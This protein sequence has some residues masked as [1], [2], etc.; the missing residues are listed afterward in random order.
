MIEPREQRA[1]KRTEIR[2]R[3]ACLDDSSSY[4]DRVGRFMSRQDIRSLVSDLLRDVSEEEDIAP[5]AVP[6]IVSVVQEF[7]AEDLLRNIGEFTKKHFRIYWLTLR[8]GRASDH[9]PFELV[10][11]LDRAGVVSHFSAL[12]FHDLTEI[13][14][15]AH[16]LTA[17]KNRPTRRASVAD[18]RDATQDARG[19]QNRRS[20]SAAPKIGTMC[21]S[22]AGIEYRLR[23]SYPEQIF[24][25]LEEWTDDYERIRVFEFER[26]LL[27][28]VNDPACNGGMRGVIEAWEKGAE[29]I[30][31]ERLEGH[32]NRFDRSSLWRRVGVLA[33]HVGR[34][35]VS[36]MVG[37]AIP[38]GDWADDPLPLVWNRTK[39]SI[40]MPWNVIVPW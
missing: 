20:D 21:F 6:S 1:Y 22:H 5:S 29:K 26:A 4:S 14:A 28:A 32:L 39:G 17:P 40:V 16:F 30:R 15:S 34:N 13:R 18:V 12:V 2:F 37:N 36:E 38:I 24:G 10:S 33:D 25:V 27:D 35:D 31:Q 3:K 19:D 23:R 7:L 9:N 11:S 8:G